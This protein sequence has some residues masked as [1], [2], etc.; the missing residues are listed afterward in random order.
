MKLL[1]KMKDDDIN[2]VIALINTHDDDDAAEA[3]KDYRDVAGFYDQFVL[4]QDGMIIGVTGF[5]TPPGCDNTH[6]LSWTYIHSD[7]T[8]QGL[9]RKI[10]T[11]LIEHLTALDSRKLFIKVSD[12]VSAEDGAIYAAALH[13]Y[14]SLGFS[15]D[16]THEDF[17][18]V[19]ESQ[20]ILG[21]RLKPAPKNMAENITANTA[22]DEHKPLQFNSIY[23]IA[24]TED[25]Y[26]FG[27]HD[28]G[29]QLFTAEDV[30]L[31]LDSA[32]EEEAR[33]VFLTFP[34][35]YI[36]VNEVL[37]DVGFNQAG[38]LNNYYEEGVHEQHYSYKFN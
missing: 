34:S 4:E 13:L 9:G 23:E 7:H 25:V 35:N 6:W 26:S 38:V 17:Y 1:R 2:A 33:A 16:I 36:G 12:Y 10:I 14:Q 21:M 27:W 3:E 19:G 8:N 30:Q 24:E 20:I 22:T 18:D 32:R 5:K 11:E 37:L 15:I 29:D 28:E 31:G